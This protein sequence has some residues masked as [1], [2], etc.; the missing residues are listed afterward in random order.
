MKAL[1]DWWPMLAGILLA[2]LWLGAL[3][4]RVDELERRQRFEHGTYDLP[5]GAP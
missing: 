1:R 2:G 3:A 5:R 4:Q